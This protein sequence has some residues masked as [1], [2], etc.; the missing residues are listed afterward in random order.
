[1]TS[2]LIIL[3]GPARSGK[4]ERLLGIYRA[5]LRDGPPRSTLWLTPT[6]RSAADILARLPGPELPGCLSPG[7]L[8]FESFAR[9]VLAASGRP[10]Q[11][12]STLMKRQLV[13]F[14]IQ[15]RRKAGKLRYFAPI[16][17]THGLVDLV[18]AFISEMKRLEIWPEEFRRACVARGWREKD[19]ELV[20]IYEA[21]QERLREHGLYDAEGRFWS[22]RDLLSGGQ[23]QPLERLRLV[24]VDG[25]AD[26]TRTQHEILGLIARRA[27]AMYVSL[28]LEG[29]PRRDDLFAKTLQTLH[30]LERRAPQ[31]VSVETMPRRADGQWPAM[32][33]LEAELFQSPRQA[34]E[35]PDVQRIEMIAASREQGEIEQIGRRIKRLLTDGTDGVDGEGS[36]RVAV[37]PAEIAV[38]FRSL[39]DVAPL[40]RE[41]F[42]EL[43]IPLDIEMS[44]TLDETPLAA[45]VVAVLRLAVADWPFRHL[46]AL[47]GSSYFQPQWPEWRESAAAAAAERAVRS[48]Q[49]PSGAQKLIGALG[50]RSERL[51]RQLAT[52]SGDDP[53]R[54]RRLQQELAD[55]QGATALLSRLRE[56]LA[57]LP[58]RASQSQWAEALEQLAGE[59]GMLR[60]IELGEQDIAR[61][62]QDTWRCLLSGLRDG[63]A[64]FEKIGEQPPELTAAEFVELLLDLLRWQRLPRRDDGVGR[65]RVLSA[66]SV[67]AL[68]VPYLFFAGLSER[69]FPSPDRQDRLYSDGEYRQLRQRSPDLPLPLRQERHQEE[70]L[71][72]YEVLTRATRQIWLSY[73]ALDA[74]AEP[75]L[76]SPY[77]REVERALGGESQVPRHVSLDLCGVPRSEHGPQSERDLRLQ[78]VG[79]ALGGDARLLA[80]LPADGA[81]GLRRCVLDGLALTHERAG[82]EFGRFEGILSSAAAQADVARRYGP[83]LRWTASHLEQYALCPHQFFLQRLLGLEPL[84]ELALEPDYLQRGGLIHDV[85]AELHRSLNTGQGRPSS[86]AG[87]DTAQWEAAAT[88]AMR[89]VLEQTGAEH[90]VQAALREIDRRIIRRWIQSYLGQHGQYDGKWSGFE[91]SPLPAHFEVS[92]GL[93]PLS[94]DELSTD[95]PWEVEHNGEKLLLCGRIDRLDRGQHKGRQ[96]F[97]VIDYK[98]GQVRPRVDRE[99]PDG[100]QLQLELYALAAQELLFAGQAVPL[101]VGYWYVKQEGFKGSEPLHEIGGVGKGQ[102][103]GACQPSDFWRDRKRQVLDKVFALV[104]GV[105][106]AEFPMASLDEHCTSRCAFKTVCR[107]NHARALEKTWQLPGGSKPSS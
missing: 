91:E 44:E 94:E 11:P 6:R 78:A 66:A 23:A 52:F 38:V 67:R 30:A 53:R 80:T 31:G 55:A 22:A 103:D 69:A 12:I 51:A 32:Q 77:L 107:V 42:G 68:Q 20:A 105:R 57:A 5:A 26:F 62:D 36:A 61:R 59:I 17:D 65:V 82:Q 33:H 28:P 54:P 16:A 72:F 74:K 85:L 50:R 10:F 27:E 40:V 43:G 13:R 29:E 48:L 70:M 86:P 8:T 79:Q 88:S 24:V 102:D 100:R 64:L 46:L 56:A 87:C 35:A 49:I 39:G 2:P 106:A 90:D 7:V 45:A 84:E 96:I 93:N 9:E 3:T 92:F 98:S 14:L 60:V 4:T 1:M 37:R 71:L 41:T 34:R 81:D 47:L 104:R 99:A 21:Y 76:P 101:H 89:R 75:L 58:T 83:Q 73:P 19:G 25:F 63:G 97:N 18:V 95:R 15:Q